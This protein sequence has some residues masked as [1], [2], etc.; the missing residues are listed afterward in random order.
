MRGSGTR[1]DPFIIESVAGFQPLPGGSDGTDVAFGGTLVGEAYFR[2]AALVVGPSGLF[3]DVTAWNGILTSVNEA[4]NVETQASG[5]PAP[6][7]GGTDTASTFGAPGAGP[8][9]RLQN[10]GPAGVNKRALIA[11]KLA[12]GTTFAPPPLEPPLVPLRGSGTQADPFVI[13]PARGSTTISPWPSGGQVWFSA[14]TLTNAKLSLMTARDA[15]NQAAAVTALV[16]QAGHPDGTSLVDVITYAGLPSL[17]RLTS[18][19]LVPVIVS[20]NFTGKIAPKLQGSGTAGDPYLMTTADGRLRVVD[21]SQNPVHFKV[22]PSVGPIT[23]SMASSPVAATK[24]LIVNA[25]AL[26]LSDQLRNVTTNVDSS[27][28]LIK[29]DAQEPSNPN[30]YPV[31]SIEF[32]DTSVNLVMSPAPTPGG[33]FVSP[34]RHFGQ[35]AL[36]EGDYELN[37]DWV[38]GPPDVDGNRME[39]YIGAGF[40]AGA[41]LSTGLNFDSSANI[42]G[43]VQQLSLE[44]FG[45]TVAAPFGGSNYAGISTARYSS[46]GSAYGGVY[47]SLNQ[48]Y[49]IGQVVKLRVLL[50]DG[51]LKLWVDGVLRIDDPSGRLTPTTPPANV[52]A[53][54]TA[55][56]AA[57]VGTADTSV[58]LTQPGLAN[59]ANSGIGS[60]VNFVLDAVSVTKPAL[61]AVTSADSAPTTIRWHLS[62]AAPRP[63]ANVLPGTLGF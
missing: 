24:E 25:V 49:S 61:I 35:T 20:W 15:L 31:G 4:D 28:L 36:T 14:T 52:P 55:W 5:V 59:I 7:N 19:N 50:R 60:G 6:S 29:N 13:S 8:L 34:F 18:S 42:N 44:F 11:W 37:A 23:L 32:N 41:D 47:F 51:R 57:D 1:V 56:A 40:L 3:S 21:W 16:T 43:I 38:L 9:Y 48:P 39:I 2:L 27:W 33:Q 58:L 46:T 63:A 26:S 17:I 54:I 12:A 45:P 30:A 10:H 22:Y 53:A 62:G